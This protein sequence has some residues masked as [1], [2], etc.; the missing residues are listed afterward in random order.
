MARRKLKRKFN[1]TLEEEAAFYADLDAK[2]MVL[3]YRDSLVSTDFNSLI[4]PGCRLYNSVIEQSIMKY[5]SSIFK[6]EPKIFKE[7]KRNKGN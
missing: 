4:K 7:T 3:D 5:H 6:V 1:G 2:H